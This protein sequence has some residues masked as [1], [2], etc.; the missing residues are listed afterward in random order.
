[1]TR[2]YHILRPFLKPALLL[3]LVSS[4]FQCQKHTS[5]DPLSIPP[6]IW[7][8]TGKLVIAGTCANYVIQVPA[9]E[10]DSSLV[11]ASWKDPSTDSVYTNVFT[12]SSYCTFAA[13]NLVKGDS[14]S[15]SFDPSPP[16]QT[17]TRCDIYVPTPSVTHAV[18]NV[19]KITPP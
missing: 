3:L 2:P 15:F 18:M 10:V 17:C 1:M 14:I 7:I 8:Y 5:I 11:M 19:N 12:V 6:A 9:G 13:Y 4:G 16:A